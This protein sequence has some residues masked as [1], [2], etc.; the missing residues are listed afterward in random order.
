MTEHQLSYSDCPTV[1]S[2]QPINRDVHPATRGEF[3]RWQPVIAQCYNN[4][5]DNKTNN[6]TSYGAA[7]ATATV[8]STH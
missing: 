6:N 2:L 7:T 3:S 4:G 1:V 5:N 8:W